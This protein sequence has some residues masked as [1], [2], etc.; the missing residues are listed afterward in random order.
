MTNTEF[1][2]ELVPEVGTGIKEAVMTARE[3]VPGD[4]YSGGESIELA[5]ADLYM[6]LLIMPEFS[7]GSLSIKYSASSLKEAANRIY[8]KYGDPRYNSGEPTIRKVK[9]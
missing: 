5:E 7:E 3:V 6:R 2:N 1:L 9:I 4:V 8:Q